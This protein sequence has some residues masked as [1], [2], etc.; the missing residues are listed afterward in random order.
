MINAKPCSCGSEQDSETF[1]N[2]QE[3]NIMQF[4]SS[5]ETKSKNLFPWSA[6]STVTGHDKTDQL[7]SWSICLSW[8]HP[9]FMLNN[10]FCQSVHV[11]LLLSEIL[12]ANLF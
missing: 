3:K 5:V 10:K 12:I 6:P 7:N 2:V 9:Q 8:Q 1:E 11:F 4:T